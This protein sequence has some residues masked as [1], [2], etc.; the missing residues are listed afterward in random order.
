MPAIPQ[1]FWNLQERHPGICQ[2][3]K[4]LRRIQNFK[5][6][7]KMDPCRGLVRNCAPFQS[8]GAN[9]CPRFILPTLEV[10]VTST[11]CENRLT[12]RSR[13]V[14]SRGSL[15]TSNLT[16]RNVYG[17]Q[18]NRNSNLHKTQFCHDWVKCNH[19]TRL[20]RTKVRVLQLVRMLHSEHMQ[21]SEHE[22]KSRLANS[23]TV[24]ELCKSGN[25]T[26]RKKN[27][28]ISTCWLKFHRRH[29]VFWKSLNDSEETDTLDSEMNL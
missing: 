19:L 22:L 8:S 28:N 25:R 7:A 20:I 15:Q 13:R 3:R 4:H 10:V 1:R 9:F 12:A 26:S 29:L 24:S 6:Q 11:S 23:R 14:A 21:E 17:T 27:M 2:R 16:G 5:S 18:P